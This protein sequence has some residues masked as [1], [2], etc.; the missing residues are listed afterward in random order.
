MREL[1]RKR[2]AYDATKHISV[3]MEPLRP[4]VVPNRRGIIR[5]TGTFEISVLTA[6]ST[7][8]TKAF[9]AEIARHLTKTLGRHVALAQVFL[10]LERLEDKGYVS[11]RE[12]QPEPVRGGRRRQ[13]FQLEALG[14]RAIRETATAGALSEEYGESQNVRRRTAPA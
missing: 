1:T 6:I 2:M 14:A 8:G 11:S 4:E 12:I 3:L 10:S 9:A 5:K 7:L 13:I